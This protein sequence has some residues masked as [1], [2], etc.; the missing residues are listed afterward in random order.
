SVAYEVIAGKTDATGE[1]TAAAGEAARRNGYKGDVPA[2]ASPYSD[3]IVTNGV[4][5]TLEQSQRALLAAM[6]LSAV[7]VAN[8]AVAAIEV[9]NNP[10]I[11]ALDK[12]GRASCRERVKRSVKG[13]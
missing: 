2:V 3:R 12:I 10:C 9:L 8:T 1:L 13:G 7:T 5:V 11:L 4:T 6:F